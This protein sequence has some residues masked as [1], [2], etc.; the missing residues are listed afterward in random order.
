[1]TPEQAEIRLNAA[2]ARLKELQER[3]ERHARTGNSA[4]LAVT[5]PIMPRWLARLLGR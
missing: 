5:A 2:I 1:M 3:R 4:P